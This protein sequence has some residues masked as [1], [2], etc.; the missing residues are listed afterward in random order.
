MVVEVVA[1]ET[2]DEVNPRWTAFGRRHARKQDKNDRLDARSVA[3]LVWRE[4]SAHPEVVTEDETAVLSLLVSERE[5]ALAEA[6][7]LRNQIHQLLL[8][9]DPEYQAH[10]PKLKSK[11]GLEALERYVTTSGSAVQ[12]QRAAAVRRLAQRLRLALEQ[13]NDLAKQIRELA[14]VRC[15][16]LTELFGINLLT[17]GALVGILGPGQRFKSEA[18]LAAYGGVAP[19]EASSAGAVRHRLNRGGNRQLNAIL[20]RIALTQARDFADAQTYLKRRISEGKTE[21]EAIR[22]LKRYIVR[23]VWRLWQKCQE[24][25]QEKAS[26]ESQPAL[27]AA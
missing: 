19:I 2:V 15:S 24:A 6:T 1:G 12:Q 23:A 9:L 11:A 5:N 3:L 16:A 8:Q 7:R 17:A 10:L 13:A 27:T 25:L 14:Q 18:Q 4:A 21:R 22:A 26:G 20:Y